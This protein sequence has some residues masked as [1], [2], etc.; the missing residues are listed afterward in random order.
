MLRILDLSLQGETERGNPKHG[1]AKNQDMSRLMA[2]ADTRP[3]PGMESSTT[4]DISDSAVP[5]GNECQH[6]AFIVGRRCSHGG[7][8]NRT[9][10]GSDD[11]RFR[12]C[13]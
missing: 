10:P 9:F 8:N 4:V 13:Q 1:K 3:R 12:D 7:K 6:K 5:N 2:T 11:T